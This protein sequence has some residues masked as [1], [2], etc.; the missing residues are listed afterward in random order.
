M[1]KLPVVALVAGSILRG[2]G[3]AGPG[4]EADGGPR[5][6]AVVAERFAAAANHR[7]KKLYGIQFHPEVTHCEH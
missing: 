4:I 7:E 2:P 3:D 6:V 5:R 1:M